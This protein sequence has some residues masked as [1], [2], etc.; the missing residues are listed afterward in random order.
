[1]NK[2]SIGLLASGIAL[3]GIGGYWLGR[4]APPA[5]AAPALDEPPAKRIEAPPA[6]SGQAAERER[7]D[8]Y[9]NI[10]SVEQILALPG[11]FAQTE[12]LYVVA[13]R[14]DARGVQRLIAEMDGVKDPADRRAGLRILF[15]RYAELDPA[16]AVALSRA[17]RFAADASLEATVWQTWARR[18][19]D[20]A[21]D[22]AAALPQGGRREQAAQTIARSAMRDES[23]GL[24]R[25][26]SRLGG[27]DTAKLP[28]RSLADR[29]VLA[30]RDA[31][32]EAMTLPSSGQRQRALAL[33]GT[34]LARGDP[35][36]ALEYSAAIERTGLRRIYER[37]VF[38]AQIESDPEGALE[39]LRTGLH[40]PFR[41]MHVAQAIGGLARRDPARAIA[42]A[43]DIARHDLRSQAMSM[44][45]RSWAE[46]D[47][48]AAA[49]GL[50]TIDNVMLR[51]QSSAFVARAYADVAPQ[52]AMTWA[53]EVDPDGSEG[54]LGGVLQ[55]IAASDPDAAYNNAMGIAGASARRSALSSVLQ[56][57]ARADPE[58]AVAYLQ[59]TDKR[60]VADSVVLTI[61]H[62]WVHHDPEASVEWLIGQGQPPHM[63]A[64]ASIGSE[65]AMS[66]P[67]AAAALLPRLPPRARTAWAQSIA[68]QY[69]RKDMAK[70]RAFLAGYRDDPAYGR[71]AGAAV[72]QLAQS[73]P[74]R[75]L[76]LASEIPATAK[77]QWAT[78]HAVDRLAATN[79]RR[80]AAW[81]R[82]F[83]DTGQRASAAG[84]VAQQWHRQ[85]PAGAAAW[86]RA[87]PE[88]AERDQA[89]A[90]IFSVRG[91]TG[92]D[93]PSQRLLDLISDPGTR[94][95]AVRSHLMTLASFRGRE[96]AMAE[97]ERLDLGRDQREQLRQML[98]N[99][100]ASN[101]G[102]MLRQFRQW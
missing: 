7:R 26:D 91:R 3:G 29:A 102:V 83:D 58:Q 68:Q 92:Y 75:A 71:I 80:A 46:T 69:A 6:M 28:I 24:E 39:Q 84:A 42:L 14:A 48:Q 4:D 81:V 100:E 76:E 67:E 44:A 5:P 37:A 57:V 19:L 31:I 21:I 64:L 97:L 20:A 62:Q 47:P 93:P 59:A 77:A 11:D 73:E 54:V 79:P 53:R 94:Q 95:Q 9:R 82:R 49:A 63:N 50:A 72:M 78:R 61:A 88:G 13:G 34:T 60:D 32:A 86:V 90:S 1:M 74:E 98:Q 2:L 18:D 40:D 33:I 70:T 17:G 8:H 66:D 23:A 45:F 85:D 65:I 10:E 99:V 12:A 56:T 16:G 55:G 38:A 27:V 15:S 89:V 101:P 22:A 87:M 51:R 35:E 43:R 30:P 25:V 52:E 96:S 41:R 36:A